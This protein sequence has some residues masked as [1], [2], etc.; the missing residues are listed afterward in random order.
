[1]TFTADDQDGGVSTETLVVVVGNIAPQIS[2]TPPMYGQQGVVYSYQ[3][4]VLD[5][6]DEV[7]LWT[8]APS[9]PATMTIDPG[10]GLLTWTPS[11]ADSL[12]GSVAVTLTVDDQDGGTD[13]QSWSITIGYSDADGDGIADSWETDNGL[14]PNDPND[15]D[16]DADGDGVSNVDEFAAGTDPNSFD[17]PEA[18]ILVSPI[19]D[20]EVD[21]SVPFL[22][23]A[24]SFD[25]QGD[26]LAYDFEVWEDAAMTVLLTDSL[27]VLEDNSGQ[28]SWKVD[29]ALAENST[30]YWRARASDGLAE[31]PYSGLE[32]FFVNELNEA[33]ETPVAQAPLDGAVLSA[34]TPLLE[35]SAA[36]DPD[37][38]FVTYSVQVHR[39]DSGE[40]D[41]EL[42]GLGG[43]DEAYGSSPCS[44]DGSYGGVTCSWTINVSLEEDQSYLWS[45]VAVDE[46]GLQGAWSE[47]EEFRYSNANEAPTGVVFLAPLDGSEL[48]T[49]SPR[50]V[51]SEGID[52]EGRELSYHFA[53]DTSANFTSELLVEGVA[54]ASGT[55]SVEW[56]LAS[57]GSELSEDT[58][59]YARVRAEDPQG[60]ASPWDVI[61]LFVRGDNAAPPVPELLA[62]AEDAYPSPCPLL[63]V[64]NVTDPEGDTVFYDFIVS[65]DAELTDIVSEHSHV[66]EGVGSEDGAEQTVW[67]AEGLPIGELYWSA[68]A[69]DEHGAASDWAATW[70]LTVPSGEPEI[71][72][73]DGVELLSGGCA[74]EASV[75]GSATPTSWLL[76]GLLGL[77]PRARRRR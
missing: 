16:S 53:L 60:L 77:V 48:E 68:R 41:V 64:G 33:P 37:G 2:S 74:C 14:D 46:H 29:V 9:A 18:P 7:F 50:L 3:P 36:G 28:T 13:V 24:N 70:P 65:S 1:M 30:V 43:H 57:E 49:L 56:D 15:A 31:G 62:P 27:D 17:G 73:L 67:M 32:S 8:L 58:T 59:W 75:L 11:Y 61:S 66:L 20:E 55:G 72:T 76:L 63:V 42:E 35:W 38:D 19:G 22:V 21:S 34:S 45:V 40:L 4:S 25:P 54:A 12:L 71:E 5:P 26:E 44:S 52:P 69:V 6:G 23:L 10:T 47:P 51:A 39:V